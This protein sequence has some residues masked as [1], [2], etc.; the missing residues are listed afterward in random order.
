MRKFTATITGRVQGVGYRAF[1]QATAAE[2]GVDAVAT[3]EPDG[4]VIVE[5]NG[6]R[7]ALE[8]LVTHLQKGPSRGNV[9]NVDVTWG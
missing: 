5:A 4:S 8:V 3:N 9:E 7:A 6:E 1:V 2:C